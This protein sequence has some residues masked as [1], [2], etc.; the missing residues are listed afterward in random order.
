MY[1]GLNRYHLNNQY[2]GVWSSHR[3]RFDDRSM[4]ECFNTRMY[5]DFV[6]I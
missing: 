6:I 2:P 4:E 3:V 5:F 1:R